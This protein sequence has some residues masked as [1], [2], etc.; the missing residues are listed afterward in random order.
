[1]LF[2]SLNHH[3]YR[4][5][6]LLPREDDVRFID[7]LRGLWHVVKRWRRK[8]SLRWQGRTLPVVG[9]IG[10]QYTLVDAGG[11]TLAPGDLLTTE[12]NMMMPHPRRKFVE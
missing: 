6:S 11:T 7:L 9:R 4:I 1:M 12:A 10:T 3:S 5:L 8:S 2:R